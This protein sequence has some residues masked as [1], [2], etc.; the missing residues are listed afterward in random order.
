MWCVLDSSLPYFWGAM[1]PLEPVNYSAHLFS[2]L[3]S[4]L[5][6]SV[7]LR[8]PLLALQRCPMSLSCSFSLWVL[9]IQMQSSRL[10]KKYFTD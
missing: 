7:C 2:C 6:G 3:A 10:R 1:S 4:E 9:G 5:Q 8:L